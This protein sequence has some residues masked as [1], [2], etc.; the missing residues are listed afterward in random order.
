LIRT[1]VKIFET[2]SQPDLET[3]MAH[4]FAGNPALYPGQVFQGWL[5]ENGGG[6]VL[7]LVWNV[8]T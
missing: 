3:Q 6:H 4:F 8:P 2:E 5:V 7:M 1:Q